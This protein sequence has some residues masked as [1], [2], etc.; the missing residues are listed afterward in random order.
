MSHFSVW[1]IGDPHLSFGVPHKEMDL[2][3]PLW[4]NRADKIKA[5]WDATVA[6]DDI[7]LIPGDIS[8]AMRIEEALPDLQWIDE[9][10][11]IKILIKG[12]HDYWWGSISKVGASRFQRASA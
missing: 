4:K 8:W 9:R 3:G 2:F 7:V 10:P 6:P 5:A 1:A 12:N 11:G